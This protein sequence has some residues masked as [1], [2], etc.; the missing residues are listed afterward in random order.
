MLVTIC[1]DV[2]SSMVLVHRESR[3][4][5]PK[6]KVRFDFVVWISRLKPRME[7]AYHRDIRVHEGDK[8]PAPYQCAFF[9]SWASVDS[10]YSESI[11]CQMDACIIGTIENNQLSQSCFLMSINSN[12]LCLCRPLAPQRFSACPPSIDLVGDPDPM[13]S[14]VDPDGEEIYADG[15]QYVRILERSDMFCSVQVCNELSP[16]VSAL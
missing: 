6:R 9:S 14:Q 11:L 16:R 13:V 5:F 7:R 3:V 8:L 10:D 12:S 4:T 1:R 15:N 2:V